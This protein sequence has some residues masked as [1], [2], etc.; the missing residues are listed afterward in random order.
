V[1]LVLFPKRLQALALC[2]RRESS[3]AD[4]LQQLH[5]SIAAAGKLCERRA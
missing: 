3:S 2:E 4:S 5:C 1:K